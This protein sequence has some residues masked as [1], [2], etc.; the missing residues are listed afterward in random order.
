HPP[1]S[2]TPRISVQDQGGEW[3]QSTDTPTQVPAQSTHA[4]TRA[5]PLPDRGLWCSCT[6]TG[7]AERNTC[8]SRH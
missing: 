7:L 3:P 6:E 5:P 2:N 1:F 4:P 8:S